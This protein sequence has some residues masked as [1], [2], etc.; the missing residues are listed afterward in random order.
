MPR[1]SSMKK[2]WY[3]I[4]A[5]L[6]I[7]L[8][9]GAFQFV[10][11]PTPTR[12]ATVGSTA[13]EYARSA[14]S[15]VD[16][17]GV[18]THFGYEDSSYVPYRDYSN[19]KVWL[20]NL[21]VRHIRDGSDIQASSAKLWM[22]DTFKNLFN[23][24]GIKTTFATS[25]NYG[26]TPTDAINMINRVTPQALDAVEGANEPDNTAIGGM[27]DTAA[28]QWQNGIY[29][30]IHGSTDAN[31]NHISVVGPTPIYGYAPLAPLT[32]SMDYQ[33]MHP[34][35]GAWPIN[36]SIDRN[37]AQADQIAGSGYPNKP[38]YATETGY[39]IGTGTNG[40]DQRAAGIYTPRMFAELFNRG[41]VRTHYYQ[42]VQMGEVTHGLMNVTSWIDDS[43]VGTWVYQPSYLA[44]KDIIGL[45]NESTWN[46]TTKQWSTPSFIPG[47]LDYAISGPTRKSEFYGGANIHHT[48]LQKSN[49]TF[50][51]MIW[52]EIRSFDGNAK[53]DIVN[54]DVPVNLALSTPIQGATIYR[55]ADDGT[56]SSSA[57]TISGSAGN[58]TISL[59]VPDR[60]MVVQLTPNNASFGQTGQILNEQWNNVSGT[61]V[62][63]IPVNTPPSSIDTWTS[64]E[65]PVN[66]ADNFGRRIRGY[67][68]APV[69]GPYRFWIASDDNSQLWISRSYDPGQKQLIAHVDDWTNSR[70]W[71]KY[72]TQKSQL[73][74]LEQGK[75]YYIEVLQK[76]GGG[77][78]N[79]AVGWAKP[80]SALTA[81]T[82]VEIVPGSVLR[83]YTINTITDN[84]DN[85]NQTYSH[86]SNWLVR[87]VTDGNNNA[88]DT[89]V[90]FKNNSDSTTESIVWKFNGLDNFWGLGYDEFNGAYDI[91]SYIQFSAS[92]DGTTWKPIA[93][94]AERDGM[95]AGQVYNT[96]KI[97]YWIST[98][99]PL[100]SN[101][102]YIKYE[103]KAGSNS[104]GGF[105][106]GYLS[107]S[108]NRTGSSIAPGQQLFWDDFESGSSGQWS[109]AS[110]TWGVCQVGSNSK[111]YCGSDPNENISLA[112]SSSW[113][114]Y[115]VQGYVVANSNSGGICLLGRVQDST[116][117]YQ[118]E[119]KQANGWYLFQRNGSSTWNAIASGSF[120]FASNTYYLLRLDMNGS[121]LTASYS[122]DYGSTWNTL[123]SGNDSTYS[124]GGIGVRVWGTAGRFDQI[125]VISD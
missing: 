60:V 18:N 59:N 67:L 27:G 94:K 120:N 46:S 28:I 43:H 73:I 112:G 47:A 123:G 33:N 118:L 69:T 12:A 76:E 75:S 102:S 50:Y 79:V 65:A 51:L 63:N 71:N 74:Y 6:L 2:R 40:V 66:V 95:T 114:N 98:V 9:G 83:P 35:P 61:S 100:P 31:I 22:Q 1:S 72:S 70:E 13:T 80:D 34:Y 122:T 14:D 37:M 124:S 29:S 90:A 57:A 64:L 26:A 77:G 58:Q 23:D 87:S 19:T 30:A 110:G 52:N 8:S 103:V 20:T 86:T 16:S 44:V 49:G 85:W 32:G 88:V 10:H 104:S 5:A 111:E 115:S 56:M 119:L 38:F 84:L 113:T 45:F 101:T 96:A 97:K 105:G 81:S 24:T 93:V 48:L 82:P 21:G 99:A 107:F 15:F 91:T 68:T 3:F 54:Q 89:A 116:H 106:L 125:K 41:V 39:E 42:L 4:L 53:T 11:S 117:F 55:I 36:E 92:A 17:I 121:T 109:P 62:S 78:D 7:C 25:P 108:Y